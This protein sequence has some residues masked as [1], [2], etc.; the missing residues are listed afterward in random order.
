MERRSS[1]EVMEEWML[2]KVAGQKCLF[3]VEGGNGVVP[4]E[5]GFEECLQADGF[6]E[7]RGPRLLVHGEGSKKVMC[8]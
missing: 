4:C 5:F 3:M 1:V 7:K 2:V 8:G 6:G